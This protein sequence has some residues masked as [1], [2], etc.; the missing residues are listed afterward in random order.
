MSGDHQARSTAT[1]DVGGGGG[2]L[3]VLVVDDDDLMRAGLRA[4]LS[5]DETIVVNV[6]GDEPQLPSALI[7]QVE[8]ERLKTIV[9]Q[10]KERVNEG[11]SLADALTEHPKAFSTLYVNMVRSGEHSGALDVVLVRLADFTEAQA[12][13]RS[14]IMGTMLYPAIMMGVGLTIVMVLMTVVVPKIS[15]MFEDMGA[16]LPI[17]TRI[18]IGASSFATSY[19]YVMAALA[20]VALWFFLRWKNTEAGR[21]KWDAL[22]LRVPVLGPLIRMLS[23]ARFSRTLSTLLKSGVPLLTAMGIVRALVTNTVLGK[24][25]DNV[26]DSVREG[27]SIAGPLKRSGEFPPIVYHMIAVGEK[28]GQLEDM[29]ANVADAYDSQVETRISALTSL[30]EPVMIVMMGAVVAFIVFSIL[31]PI[32]QMNTMVG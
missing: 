28:S 20:A 10:V 3:R 4:V 15:A 13:L 24:V 6:Q 30:L 1:P 9:T 11:A 8:H 29:L 17:L 19:W 21:A 27:E 7:D 14:K 26:R 2:R 18:L 12:R 31:M 25:I 23:I 22:L 32:L 5:S 16:T